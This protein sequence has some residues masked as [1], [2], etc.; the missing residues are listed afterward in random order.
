MEPELYFLADRR[1]PNPY[2]VSLLP[3]WSKNPQMAINKMIQSLI[4]KKP[5]YIIVHEEWANYP[6]Y[7]ELTGLM[8]MS[9][10]REVVLGWSYYRFYL[11]RLNGA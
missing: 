7:S 6:G 3:G 1:C 4:N 10:H 2:L 5:K 8:Q 11:Y 9:Y